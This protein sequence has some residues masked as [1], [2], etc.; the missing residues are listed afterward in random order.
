MKREEI[1]IRDPFILADK[2]TETYYMYGTT[3]LEKDSYASR[4]VFSVYTSKDLEEFQGPFVVLV[5]KRK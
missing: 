4:P 1:R 3:D 5:L 2:K